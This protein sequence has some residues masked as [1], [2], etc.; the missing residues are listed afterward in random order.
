MI[1]VVEAAK[2]TNDLTAPVTGT[3]TKILVP[4]DE[5]VPVR[6]VLAHIT[7]R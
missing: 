4:V 5:S 2:A 7:P 6:T 1:G 3:L